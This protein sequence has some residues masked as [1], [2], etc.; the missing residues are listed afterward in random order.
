MKP[1]GLVTG[2]AAS[3]SPSANRSDAAKSVISLKAAGTLVTL[4]QKK[5]APHKLGSLGF[6]FPCHIMI[7]EFLPSFGVT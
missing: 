2:A 5:H 1:A 3:S 4:P 7:K 6:L